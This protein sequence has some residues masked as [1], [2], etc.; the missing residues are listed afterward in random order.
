MEAEDRRMDFHLFCPRLHNLI[1]H[2]VSV[3]LL[4]IVEARVSGFPRKKGTETLAKGKGL[5]Q[6]DI[7][8]N[9]DHVSRY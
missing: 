2:I 8:S 7:Y 1:K 3:H 5:A 9:R 6:Q 4:L